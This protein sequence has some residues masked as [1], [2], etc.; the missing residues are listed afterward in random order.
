MQALAAANAKRYGAVLVGVLVEH[1]AG[2]Q[3]PHL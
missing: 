2:R 1:D 3:F